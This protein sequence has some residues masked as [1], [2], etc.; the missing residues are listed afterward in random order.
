M[1]YT[2]LY[3]AILNDDNSKVTELMSQLI[4]ALMGF[5]R[6]S[7]RASD[8]DAKD[9]I[10]QAL[11]L[12][13]EKIKEDKIRDPSKLKFYLL[14]A[15]RNIYLRMIKHHNISLDET[16]PYHAVEPAKQL[17]NLLDEEKQRLLSFCLEHLNTDYYEFINYW[18]E[19]PDTDA[20]TVAKFFNI[21]VNNAWIRKHRIIKMLNECIENEINK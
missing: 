7:M 6:A 4:P 19:N 17:K 13:I 18:L 11:L 15:C 9:C 3:D 10:Q 20:P 1:D 21:S 14:T 12:T 5:L 2:E 8:A 16:N